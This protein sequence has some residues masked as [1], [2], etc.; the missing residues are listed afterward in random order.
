MGE[1]TYQEFI[2]KFKLDYKNGASFLK[3]YLSGGIATKVKKNNKL[4]L[5]DLT[6]PKSILSTSKRIEFIL[7]LS[8]LLFTMRNERFHGSILSP[9]MTSKSLIQRYQSYY[10]AMLS[11]YIFS[12]GLLDL[13]KL[14]TVGGVE[15]YKCC[16]QNLI[17]QD[18]FFS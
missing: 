18:S 16:E 4:G 2:S 1:D 3:P 10:Y 17:L 11:A 12:L 5:L 9:F 7:S 8:L 14:G 13:K 15:V 6:N